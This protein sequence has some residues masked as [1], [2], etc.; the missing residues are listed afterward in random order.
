MLEYFNP[1]EYE[2]ASKL[3]PERLLEYYIEDFNYSRFIHSTRNVFLVGERGTGKTMALCFN[4]LPVQL[5]YA[6][7]KKKDI[8]LSIISIYVPC[9]TPLTHK[10]EYEL[11]DELHASMVSEHFLVISIMDKVVEALSKID[12]LMTKN[13]ESDLND[14]LS[15]I[16]GIELPENKSFFRALHRVLE[17]KNRNAQEAL[18]KIEEEK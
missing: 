15:Y 10:R 5:I 12:D 6:E 3:E 4:S 13:E 7:K 1:F 8:D 11:I 16:L 14:D 9:N 18:N 17:Q 2:A